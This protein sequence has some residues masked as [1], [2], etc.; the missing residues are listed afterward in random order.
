MYTKI[1]LAGGSGYLGQVLTH[2]YKAKAKEII[3]LSRQ[4]FAQRGNI[5]F[6]QWDGKSKGEW[7]KELEGADLLVNL[8]GK[9]VNCRYTAKNRA[10]ILKSRVVPTE[11]LLDVVK[12]LIYPPKVWLQCASATIY[13]H[14]EDRYQD[15]ERGEIGT[16]FSVDVCK[17]WES[18]FMRAD[19]AGVRK[20]VLR[21]SMVLGENDGVF[22]Q[23]KNLVHAGLGGHQGN[24]RQYVSWIH[25]QDFARITE[26]ILMHEKMEGVFNVTAPEAISNCDLMKLLRKTYNIPF[27]IPTP[28]WLLE[29]G[30]FIIG[31][32]TELVFKSRWVYPKRLVESGFRFQYPQA[33]LAIQDL[34]S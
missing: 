16:G 29:I 25:E 22:P 17:T 24:G 15:E 18:C 5:T 20:A 13:R 9:N 30:A 1:I 19:L 14:A 12:E 28:S 11:L 6:L 7:V 3:V 31:T 2:Y 4:A 8:C 10:A 26:W 23:L 21:V 32:E 34:V 27:G 33:N